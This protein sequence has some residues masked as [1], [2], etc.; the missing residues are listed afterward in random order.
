MAYSQPS[1]RSTGDVITAA[2][3]NQDVVA[4][5]IAMTPHGFS[6]IID[7]GGAAI[8]AGIK[9]DIYV[10]ARC[11]LVKVTQLADTSGSIVTD[12]WKTTYS[13]FD[14]STHPVA[15]DSI[16]STSK[17]TIASAHKSQDSTLLNWT[18]QWEEGDVV[19]VNVDS[20]T[21]ITRETLAGNVSYN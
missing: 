5:M 10:P 14:N 7:G 6:A 11:S 16:C 17:P 20:C 15:A 19:R 13:L 4:N 12:L 1:N 18:V 9:F 2:I 3:W 21:S 8:T